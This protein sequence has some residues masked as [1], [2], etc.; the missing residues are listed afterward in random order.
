M[1]RRTSTSKAKANEV[2]PSRIRI[3]GTLAYIGYGSGGYGAVP[4]SQVSIIPS[5]D[6][7]TEYRDILSSLYMNANVD[8]KWLPDF[9]T[10]DKDRINLSSRFDIPVLCSDK[11]VPVE[12]T[13]RKFLEDYGTP[14]KG[15][16]ISIIAKF[17]DGSLYPVA[18][19]FNDDLSDIETYSLSNLFS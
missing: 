9:I 18:V 16:D 10:K 6:K 4:K 14:V 1:A 2:V 12:T 8:E 5:P 11:G 19:K 3:D 17:K 7:V 13:I 15:A